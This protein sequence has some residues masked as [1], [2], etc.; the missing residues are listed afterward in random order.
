MQMKPLK[1]NRDIKI[2]FIIVSCG[3][4]F[5]PIPVKALPLGGGLR[6]ALTGTGKY[7]DD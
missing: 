1:P 2:W 3:F 7:A 4:S 6:P 5:F